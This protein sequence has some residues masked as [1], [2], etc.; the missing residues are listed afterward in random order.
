MKV[1]RLAGVVFATVAIG[2]VSQLFGCATGEDKTIVSV[3]GEKITKSALDN[4]LENQAG[5]T[6]LQQ[7][8]DTSLVLQY[9]K[10]AGI[11]PTD[12]QIQDQINQLEQRFPPGQFDTILKQQGLTMDDVK[13]IE[14]VQLIIKQAVDKQI[15]V[16][17]ADITD[18]FNKNK[19]M[20]NTPAQVRARHIL[21]KTKPEADAIEAKLKQGQDFATLAKQYS[22][23][24]GSKAQGGELGWFSAQQMVKPF[25]DAAFA[26]NVGQISQPV[27][28]PF[29]WH[30]IQVEGKRP[31]HEATLAEAA[32][33]IRD[34]LTQQQ[35]ASQG[36]PFIQG[37]R[38]KA[39][40]QVYDARFN[41]LFPPPVTGPMG[42]SPAPSGQ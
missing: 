4:R 25:S 40:I 16:S 22:T 29:G 23:D 32:P 41:P 33:K 27:N 30:I 39:N 9:G 35:E 6:T 5:K 19:A 13:T 7:M 10:Q 31:A 14:K 18:Y 24:P 28:T 36:A 21:V 15:N 3:N 42:G 1:Q 17:Q 20:Y 38:A 34:S 37:L 2:L 8:V 12:A 11:N 26:L